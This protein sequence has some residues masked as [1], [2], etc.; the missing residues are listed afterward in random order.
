MLSRSLNNYY[1][2]FLLVLFIS[3]V[4]QRSVAQSY[5]YLYGND[6]I[7][8][9]FIS[10][11]ETSNKNLIILSNQKAFDSNA[12][13]DEGEYPIEGYLSL[14]TT[15]HK[16]NNSG[17]LL[18][19]YTHYNPYPD[20]SRI[21]SKKIKILPNGNLVIPYLKYM[22]IG[23]CDQI[24]GNEYNRIGV[25]CLDSNGTV[26]YDSLYPSP[27]CNGLDYVNINI[28]PMNDN[29]SWLVNYFPEYI[30]FVKISSAGNH[31]EKIIKQLHIE[32]LDIIRNNSC[33]YLLAGIKKDEKKLY[34][35]FLDTLFN[36]ISDK[37]IIMTDYPSEYT[38]KISK[39]HDDCYVI[40]RDTELIKTD[41]DGDILWNISFSNTLQSFTE[42]NPTNYLITYNIYDTTG[43]VLN[44]SLLLNEDGEIV[45]ALVN[46]NKNHTIKE[47]IYNA[48]Y[49][50]F[51]GDTNCCYTE[52]GK[53]SKLLIKKQPSILLNSNTI[54][55]EVKIVLQQ[56]T[57]DKI[58]LIVDSENVSD[59]SYEIYDVRGNRLSKAKVN[60]KE[61]L[62]DISTLRDG[63]YLVKITNQNE[64]YYKK[65][66]K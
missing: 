59:F 21:G 32:P 27:P 35:L 64:Y 1:N 18:W 29:T 20:G 28:L 25:L 7:S 51:L 5:H 60:T 9:H 66:I 3:L 23:L 36:L 48:N 52:K 49:S 16:L 11:F 2:G 53:P 8:D 10:S 22:G 30:E 44:Q 63:F 42:V 65:F 24:I 17:Q 40:I 39:T 31:Q 54:R 37:E 47:I 4:F 6:S 62:I 38:T 34:F 46:T 58:R 43:D 57:E 14:S 19:N 61:T 55:K 45:N 15:I 41:S 12:N 13:P 33:G 56:L 50:I 26:I